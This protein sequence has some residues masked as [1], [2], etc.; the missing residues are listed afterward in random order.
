MEDKIKII[1]REEEIRILEECY[2]S[3]QPEFLAVY[4]RRR[5]GKTFL[6]RS[7][8]GQKNALFLDITGMQDG[9]MSEQIRN[10]TDAMGETFVHP[11]ARLEAG[12]TWQES[13]RTLTEYI[14]LSNH[15]KIILFFDEFPWMATQNSK[16]L[17][18]LE[19][20]WNHTWSKD[21]RVKLI[22]CGSSAGW[23][24]KNI[25]NNK[26]GLYNRVTKTIHLEPLNL[27]E[28]KKYLLHKGVKLNNKQI[29]ELYMVIG[30]IPHYLN[31]VTKGLSVA[32]II[33]KLAFTKESFLLNEFNK[34]YATLFHNAKSCIEIIRLIAKSRYGIG[35]VEL[36]E[37]ISSA[38]G[39]SKT[40]LLDDV[41]D[42]GF[43]ISFKPKGHKKKGIYYKVI[44]EYSLFYLYWIDPIKDTLLT[45]G[46]RQGYW[47]KM[48]LGHAWSIWK[49]YA[50]EAL[51]YKHLI[52]ISEVLNLSPT[53]IPTTWR[54]APLTKSKE[55][56]AQIDLLFDRDDDAITV[57]EIKYTAKP[58]EIDK[59]YANNLINKVEI[60][61]EKTKTSKQIFT[62]MISANGIKP[63]MYSEEL[64]TG[65]VTLDDLFAKAK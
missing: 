59:Q 8:F 47:E 65:V 61:K 34:L 25:I 29:A 16:L 11:G 31:R 63:T 44:D 40:Q 45:K 12:E 57:C 19:Y 43:I 41:E 60:F 4:G 27:K 26:K 9:D 7:F 15:K 56:G 52:R 58:F 28:T 51:C 49:G 20:F 18:F 42:A 24:L 3:N 21:N 1:S 23:I 5:V 62:A 37:K 30:G 48:Q 46:L 33:E 53:A 55:F 32:Q 35:Q 64:I 50:F 38:G 10:F 22:I 2:A 36:L 13:F 17:Q 6:I 39:G 14:R 54:Y